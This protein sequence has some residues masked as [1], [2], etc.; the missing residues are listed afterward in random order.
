M[1]LRGDSLWSIA[2][3]SLGP[4]AS[5][6]QIVAELQRWFVTNQGVIGEDP[7]L[8]VPGLVLRAP[9]RL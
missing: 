9:H 5:D 7:D 1:V 8:I 3:R 2:A 6:A 4:G